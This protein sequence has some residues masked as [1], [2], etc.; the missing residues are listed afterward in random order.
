MLNMKS[1]DPFVAAPAP[2]HP[3]TNA[4]AFRRCLQILGRLLLLALLLVYLVT[5]LTAA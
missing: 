5:R 1:I 4:R 3:Q 2:H